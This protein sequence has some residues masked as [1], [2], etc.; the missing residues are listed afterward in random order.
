MQRLMQAM[1][2]YGFLGL[3]LGRT[4]FLDSVSPASRTLAAVLR[5]LDAPSALASFLESRSV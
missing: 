1:G 5:E 4:K 2:A 3:K